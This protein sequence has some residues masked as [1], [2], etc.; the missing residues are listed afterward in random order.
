MLTIPH[1]YLNVTGASRRK[2]IFLSLLPIRRRG[3]RMDGKESAM[4]KNWSWQFT[5]GVVIWLV[6]GTLWRSIPYLILGGLCASV[7]YVI[8]LMVAA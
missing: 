5:L 4:Y 3:Y 2:I 7:L 6:V 8:A 1:L